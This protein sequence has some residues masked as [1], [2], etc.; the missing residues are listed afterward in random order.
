M[1]TFLRSCLVVLIF[2]A[3]YP[4][5]AQGKMYTFVDEKG[6]VH[7][8]NVPNDPRYV[9]L[10][11]IKSRHPLSRSAKYIDLR[12]YEPYINSVGSRY[13]VD[14]LLIKAVIKAESNFDCRALSGKGAQGLMQLMPGTARD[15]SVADPFDPKENIRGGACYLRKMLT[16]FEDD[17]HLALAAYNAGPETV[18][19]VGGIPDIPETVDYVNKVLGHYRRYQSSSS[20]G[21]GG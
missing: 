1:L 21:K 20:F 3:L 11:K 19:N 18:K 5:G 15:M 6:V 8:S 17:V 12:D 13:R 10:D 2:C 9:L 4:V 7:F 14:P 16:L